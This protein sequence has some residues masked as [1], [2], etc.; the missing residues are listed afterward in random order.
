[1]R[2]VIV[3]S[4]FLCSILGLSFSSKAQTVE[5]QINAIRSYMSSDQRSKLDQADSYLDQ[6]NAKRANISASEERIASLVSKSET[7]DKW[8]ERRKAKKAA[9]KLAKETRKIYIETAKTYQKGFNPKHSVY[10][11]KLDELFDNTSPNADEIKALRRT[12]DQNADRANKL[13]E[14]LTAWD[15]YEK[16]SKDLGQ[17][18][19]LWEVALEKQREAFCLLIDCRS[20]EQKKAAEEARRKEREEQ[21]RL[22]REKLREQARL[23]SLKNVKQVTYRVQILAVSNEYPPERYGELYSDTTGIY[24]DYD[25]EEGLHKYLVGKFDSYTAACA[26]RDDLDNPRLRNR[27]KPFV[28]AFKSTP[29]GGVR[30][31]VI[32]AIRMTNEQ[33]PE[34]LLPEGSELLESSPSDGQ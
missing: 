5:D 15:K 29:A 33:V 27:E 25:E 19:E 18:F 13:L 34:H 17:A 26:L 23:D 2:P 6:A 21:E 28:V 24:K 1:M 22:E 12:A 8:R 14:P 32:E 4:F 30:I 3:T 31:S 20:E 9:K 16:I 7:A 10:N 11:Q